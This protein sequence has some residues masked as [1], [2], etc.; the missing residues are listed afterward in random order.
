MSRNPK[1]V[2]AAFAA[3]GAKVAG[4]QLRELT[5]STIILLEKLDSPLLKQIDGK[6]VPL[7]DFDMMRLIYV[8]CRPSADC[9]RLLEDRTF[10]AAVLTFC[11]TIPPTAL[12]AIGEQINRLFYRAMST[13][14]SGGEE[15]GGKKKDATH[16]QTSP[17]RGAA[18]AGS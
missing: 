5:I 18:A 6:T 13:A 1:K 12:P 2:V 17:E 16:S 11:E 4:I 15:S 9:L 10:D 8:L 3:A 14:P 7:S